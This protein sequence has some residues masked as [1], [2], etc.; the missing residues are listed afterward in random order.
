LGEETDASFDDDR[1][2]SINY[3]DLRECT[4]VWAVTIPGESTW[5]KSQ[6]DGPM[7]NNGVLS[8]HFHK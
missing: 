8:V 1:R 7:S 3:A 5:C 2:E 6:V 4:V